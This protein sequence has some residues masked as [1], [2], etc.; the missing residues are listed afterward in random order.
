MPTSRQAASFNL[1]LVVGFLVGL[2][3]LQFYGSSSASAELSPLMVTFANPPFD[4]QILTVDVVLIIRFFRV[5]LVYARG[6]SNR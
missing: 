2:K 3:H 4:A 1:D 6:G 5:R